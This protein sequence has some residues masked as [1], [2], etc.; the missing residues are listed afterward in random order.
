MPSPERRDLF[1]CEQNEGRG[2][3]R[4]PVTSTMYGACLRQYL[5][6]SAPP[7]RSRQGEP[8]AD[9]G[10]SNLGVVSIN[11]TSSRLK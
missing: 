3:I 7:W 2:V 4:L 8:T 5:E 1:S 9:C 6:A 11:R 10:I